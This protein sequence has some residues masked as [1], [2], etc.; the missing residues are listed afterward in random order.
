MASTLDSFD[1]AGSPA[2]PGRSVIHLCMSVNRAVY[3][4]SS[5]NLSVSAIAM[6]SK[7]SQSKVGGIFSPSLG[8]ASGGEEFA[9]G[10]QLTELASVIGF[11]GVILV[12]VGNFYDDVRR[13]VGNRLAAE[14]RLWGYPRRLV[15]FVQF[16][17]GRLVARF[18]SFFH[19]DVARRAGAHTAAR[20][21]EAGSDALGKIQNAAGQAVVPVRNF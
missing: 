16:G 5:G 6:S 13:S 20:V 7:L 4:S 18:Q 2:N 3:G 12:P 17:I 14:A 9:K 19:D 1:F 15:Q 10:S 11:F 21:V 8:L